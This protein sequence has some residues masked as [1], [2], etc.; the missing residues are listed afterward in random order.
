MSE[1]GINLLKP[2]QAALDAMLSLADEHARWITSLTL[3]RCGALSK[4]KLS[5]KLL[6]QMM[7]TPTNVRDYVRQWAL[8]DNNLASLPNVVYN[9]TTCKWNIRASRRER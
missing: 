5:V 9:A 8:S 1:T 7:E 4:A 2:T 6:I 3:Q